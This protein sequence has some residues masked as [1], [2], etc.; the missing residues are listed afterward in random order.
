MIEATNWPYRL[1]YLQTVSNANKGK[2]S[3]MSPL[4]AHVVLSM[5]ALGA[6][7]KTAMEMRQ[8][9]HLPEDDAVSRQGF[10]NLVDSLNVRND[11][12]FS[13]VA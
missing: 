1:F 13:T 7:G 11:F 9:L 8:T 12:F 2:N 3:I 5:A 4:S 6:G 10:Q